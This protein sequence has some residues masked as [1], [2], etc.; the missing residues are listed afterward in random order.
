MGFDSG[1]GQ[2]GERILVV[3]TGE[4]HQAAALVVDEVP[5]TASLDLK[6]FVGSDGTTNPRA[7]EMLLGLGEYGDS[8]LGLLDLHKVLDAASQNDGQAVP[9]QEGLLEDL[10]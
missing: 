7:A 6:R 2:R 8:V 10:T 3:P 4:G 1:V 5:G 9:M